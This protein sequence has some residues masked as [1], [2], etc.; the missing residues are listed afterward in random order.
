MQSSTF[1]FVLAV[2]LMIGVIIVTNLLFPP[3]APEPAPDITVDSAAPAVDTVAQGAAQDSPFAGTAESS[4]TVAARTAAPVTRDSAITTPPVAQDTLWVESSLYR[5]GLTSA[6]AGVVS[7]QLLRFESFTRDGVVELVADSLR[8][9][10]VRYRL[11]AGDDTLDLSSAE[12]EV[13]QRDSSGGERLLVLRGSPRGVPV[14]VSYR[15]DPE[16]Y[17]ADVE[18]SAP[19]VGAGTGLLIDIG[20]T[21]RSNE[22]RLEEDE[23]A[24]AYVVNGAQGGIRSV[25]LEDVQERRVEEGP[26][27]WVAIKNKYF[28]I[29]AM[30]GDEG[31]SGFGGLIAQDLPGA[32]AAHL[33]TTLQSTDGRYR[34]RLYMGPQEYGRLAALGSKMEDVNPYGWRIFR[35]IIQPLAHLIL[36]AIEGLHGVLGIGYGWVLILFGVLM[37]IVLWPLNSKAMRSQLKTMEL[38][39]LIKEIQARHKND[40]EKL[41]REMLRLYKEEGFNPLAGCLPLLLPWPILITLFFVFQNTISF[42]GQGFLWL[43]DLSQPDPLYL[44]PILM[45]ASIFLLQWLN[46]RAAP[47]D[48]PQMKMMT[49]FMPIIMVVIFFQFASG[50]NLYYAASNVASLPQQLQI[51]GERKR[52]R[53]RMAAK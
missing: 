4:D 33:T 20:P 26:L 34:F 2:V 14:Q 31:G 22:V 35:P 37:R 39:P 32:D 8:R 6:G 28:L 52:V 45:G 36:W 29:A 21:L 12:F 53:S 51:I 46:L 19:S 49:Y 48:N 9:A 27:E 23:R 7:A 44:L 16:R 47:Q 13:V 11:Q 43:P 25:R 50:L 3:A 5:Y 1:R 41:Q 38:Q 15:F 10:A 24:L 17:L 42:R 18:V 40:P 30:A